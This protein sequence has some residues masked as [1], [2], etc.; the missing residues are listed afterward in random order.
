MTTKP[1]LD[2]TQGR[3]QDA[4]MRAALPRKEYNAWKRAIRVLQELRSC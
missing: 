2:T 1:W 3:M 4:H